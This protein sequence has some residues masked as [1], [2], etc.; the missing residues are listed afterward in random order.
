MT[1]LAAKPN[2]PWS[3]LGHKVFSVSS[4]PS[5]QVSDVNQNNPVV[6]LVH[7]FGASTE[8][9]RHNIP[10]LS[11]SHEVHAIDLLGFGR[12][13][14]PSE[15]EYGGELWK[16]QV[17]AYVKERIGKPTVIVG[18]SLGGYAALA[19][20]AAL[21]S[22]SAG[23]VLLNAAGYFSDETLVKQPTDFFSRLR[24]FI[25]LGLSRDL[26]IK[27]FLYPLMQRLIFENLRRPNVIRNTLKQV[28]IDPT[29]VDDYLIESIR[30]PS[31][32]PGAFQV[33]RKVFQ[34]RGLKGKP[35]DEL[36]NELEAPLLLLW[37]DSD[38]WLRNA[39]A[40]QEKFLLFAREA[41]LEVKEVLLR[42]GH[43]PHD[44]IPDRVNEEM[45]AWLKG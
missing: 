7:G 19:A 24:Q 23:V 25:G 20:G 31:L 43:C 18:N 32:D 39:K 17:V 38:P 45:L 44:E 2:E 8:H 4:S 1:D 11:R 29:N 6:L 27:W 37:G 34:A 21:E 42:A 5:G 16:E 12:S 41:S 9:W 33:F 26:L 36:F 40:K 14:K 10:V 13:A 22:K 15:L 3:Y 35:I 30:R 28:Y